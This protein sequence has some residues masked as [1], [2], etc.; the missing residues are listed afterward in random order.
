MGLVNRYKESARVQ[1]QCCA[2]AGNETRVGNHSVLLPVFKYCTL[3]ITL[4]PW[5]EMPR[6]PTKGLLSGT[7]AQALIVT[8][9]FSNQM[10]FSKAP[11]IGMACHGTP[12]VPG[13]PTTPRMQATPHTTPS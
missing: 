12:G 3:H 11:L 1:A 9:Q 2:P 4:V 7:S 13:L 10:V 8:S 5:L 6:K